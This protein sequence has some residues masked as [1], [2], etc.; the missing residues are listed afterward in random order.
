MSWSLY[1][2]HAVTLLAP[3]LVEVEYIQGPGSLSRYS[4]LSQPKRKTP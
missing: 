4:L 2:F 3:H 1:G